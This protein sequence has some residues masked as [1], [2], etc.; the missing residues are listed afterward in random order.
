[1]NQE[2][3][4]EALE[5]R[6]H[7][8]CNDQARFRVLFV[9]GSPQHGKS[10]LCSIACEQNAW[11]Y[12]DFTLDSGGLDRIIGKEEEYSPE[13]FVADL[14]ALCARTSA[15]VVV[16]DE[17]EPV[18]SLWRREKQDDFFRS[19]GH[20]TRLPAGLVV[21]TRLRKVQD[22]VRLVPRKDQLL[23]IVTGEADL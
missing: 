14:R 4:L 18:L 7:D 13:E 6:V 5:K 16:V 15:Q 10:R 1:L 11:Q 23:D 8:I 2:S 19:I 22:L 20:A 9:L 3:A 17:I 12:V 21:V